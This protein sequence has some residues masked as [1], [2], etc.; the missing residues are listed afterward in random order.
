MGEGVSA[1]LSVTLPV[2][3][4]IAT[5]ILAVRLKPLGLDATDGLNR[6]VAYLALPALLF[7][8][9]ARIRWIDVAHVGFLVALGGGMAVTFVAA[10]E[11][12]ARETGI[13]RYGQPEDIAWLIA[14]LVSPPALWMTGSTLRM[15]GGEIKSV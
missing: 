10:V 12:F 13:G 15:D 8:A 3:A 14:L 2:F 5:G 7:D 6:F 1:V 11:S 9:M 4:F